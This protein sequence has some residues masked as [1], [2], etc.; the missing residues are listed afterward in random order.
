V[1][2]LRD[3][4]GERGKSARTRSRRAAPRRGHGDVGAELEILADRERREDAAAS[5]RG[6]AAAHEVVARH[7]ADRR[8]LEEDAARARR[9]HPRG[10]GERRRLAGAV[11]A[12]E[13]DDLARLHLE[14]DAVE[15]LHG[16]VRDDEVLDDEHQ[17]APGA[18]FTAV[19]AEPR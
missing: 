4:L 9:D 11:G 8:A 5:G 10:R 14:R 7:A 2:P 18:E 17:A 1:P 13:R 15:R 19:C 6:R 16:P 12:D 3:A